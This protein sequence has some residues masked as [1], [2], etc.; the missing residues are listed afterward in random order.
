MSAN[1]SRKDTSL[2]IVE[3]SFGGSDVPLVCGASSSVDARFRFAGGRVVSGSETC[4]VDVPLATTSAADMVFVD[5]VRVDGLKCLVGDQRVYA[6]GFKGLFDG[7]L[8]RSVG[9]KRGQTR[10]EMDCGCV[11]GSQDALLGCLSR[12]EMGVVVLRV[13]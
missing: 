1:K 11:S 13:V 9:D 2:V 5:Q 6:M 7:G 10:P 8:H 3:L 12:V 4:G